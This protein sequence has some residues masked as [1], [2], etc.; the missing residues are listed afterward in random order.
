MV[1][2]IG[3]ALT[4]PDNDP[5]WEFIARRNGLLYLE[6]PQP[7]FAP[8]AAEELAPYLGDGVTA[9]EW[10]AGASTLWM[11]SRG[12]RVTALETHG[13]W[14]SEVERRGRGHIDVRLVEPGTDAYFPPLDGYD[15]A[16]IDAHRRPECARH[17]LAENFTGL[18]V[19][20]DTHRREYRDALAAISDAA[21]KQR[22]FAGLSAQLTPKMTSLFWLDEH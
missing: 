17:V 11:L 19:W 12:V 2:A 16:M 18:V 5:A 4:E 1:K 6:D 15:L 3:L 7:W 8:G 9:L 14:A 13:G 21:V 20:D 22:H 10:G